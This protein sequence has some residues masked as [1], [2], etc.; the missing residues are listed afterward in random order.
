MRPFLASFFQDR[1]M[2]K[3]NATSLLAC[4]CMAASIVFVTF[5][6]HAEH[7]AYVWDFSGYWDQYKNTGRH[8]LEDW[9]DA[10]QQTQLLIASQDYNPSSILPL[11]PIYWLFGGDRAA[12]VA[13]IAV[14][15]L[16]PVAFVAAR[17]ARAD[18]GPQARLCLLTLFVA[19][20]YPAFW[21]PTLRGMVDVAGL[22]PLG[23]AALILFRTDY[24]TKASRKTAL[25]FGLLLW[26][27][28]LLR[29]WY[30]FS[31]VALVMTALLFLFA[32]ALSNRR[33]LAPVLRAAIPNYAVAGV[34]ALVA[35]GCFQPHL[36][37]RILTTNYSDSYSAY[38]ADLTGQLKIYY[39]HLGLWLLALAATGLVADLRRKRMRSA[40]GA[41]VAILTM[42]LFSRIQAPGLQHSLPVELFLFPAYVSGLLFLAQRLPAPRLAAPALGVLASLNFLSTFA[43]FGWGA[44]EPARLLFP[45]ARY[46]PLRLAQYNEYLRL[47]SDLKALEPG[48]T[49][50]V[51]ASS[52]TMSNSV[53]ATLDPTVARRL[54]YVAHVDR[55]DGFD[56]MT[57]AADYALIGEP[58]PLH[59]KAGSQK[60]IEF[61]AQDIAAGV[62]VGAAF[63]DT[64][65]RYSLDDGVT[66]Q[67][68]K[69]LRSVSAGEIGTLA[70]RFYEIYPDWRTEK[71]NVGFG[72]ASAALVRGEP[73]GAVWGGS[74][75]TLFI[76]PG[77]TQPTSVQFRIDRW[78]RPREATITVLDKN[79]LPCRQAEGLTIDIKTT[80]AAATS[81]VVTGDKPSRLPMPDSDQLIIAVAPAS[82]SSCRIAAFEFTFET[83]SAR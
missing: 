2:R 18:A 17:L 23:L 59:L 40:F 78:F 25:G 43:P 77:M 74:A 6:V 1:A 73:R 11:L 69:R 71:P 81:I 32:T 10:L 41:C 45:Q 34:T 19:F 3:T 57:L 7:P 42:A 9:R 47:I 14:I 55:R 75:E 82:G 72:L 8:F 46:G 39:D 64:G 5:Y 56:W 15:Y 70:N 67:L 68:Y 80:G 30:A 35:L 65:R 36:L 61:P 37:T 24:L 33:P 76:H 83:G 53:L 63:V 62:G 50:A 44:G 29:R 16:V 51:F 58:T 48:A 60:I 31:L 49:I 13:G 28:F 4:L 21:R 27:A 20:T 12:Y 38:Q 22:L 54:E 66:A 52:F 26:S 79:R